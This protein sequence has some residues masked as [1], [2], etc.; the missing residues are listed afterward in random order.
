MPGHMLSHVLGTYT[1]LLLSDGHEISEG[2]PVVQRPVD[3][4]AGPGDREGV[5]V[6]GKCPP[7]KNQKRRRRGK[8]QQLRI[9]GAPASTASAGKPT[10][11]AQGLSYSGCGL[12]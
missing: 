11:A 7:P 8:K 1:Y 10:H 5:G 9:A 4:E 3:E 12:G 2:E 6:P